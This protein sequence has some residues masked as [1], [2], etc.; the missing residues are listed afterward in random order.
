MLRL[1]HI[2]RRASSL[3]SVCLIAS[4][5]IAQPEPSAKA[6]YQRR[7]QEV[8]SVPGLVAFWDFVLREDAG[9]HRFTAHTASG[10]PAFPL[11]AENYIHSYWNEGRTATYAD[12]PLLGRG[13]FGQAVQFHGEADPNFRP[14]LLAPRRA[15]HNTGLDVKGPGASVSM[16]VWMIRQGGN[17]AIAGIWHEGTDLVV[18]GKRAANVQ[19]GRRQYALFAGLAA[20]DGAAAVHVSEN[21]GA[22]FGDIYARNLATTRRKIPTVPPAASADQ[23]DAAWSVVGFVFDNQKNTVTAYLD[24]EAEDYWIEQPEKHPFFRWPAH[25][26]LQAKLRRLPGLQGGEVADFPQGQFYEPPEDKPRQRRRIS[27]SANDRTWELT[28]DF[29]KVRLT[30]RRTPQGDWQPSRWE[31][32]A[33]RVNPFWFGHDLYSPATME[34]GGPFTIGRVIHSGRS[35]GTLQWIG[36]VAVFNRALSPKQM[37]RLTRI[38]RTGRAPNAPIHLLSATSDD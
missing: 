24:G 29:T 4:C 30:E 21:G 12:F 16:A 6:D 13:P 26:W 14:V 28:Y 17:H 2:L 18:G 11:D 31:L 38:G 8:R 36:G 27:V 33:L 32:L 15:I 25:A 7:V 22:S 3:L 5:A 1:L 20:N 10:A 9:A 19:A 23:L 37:R 35:V 34:D